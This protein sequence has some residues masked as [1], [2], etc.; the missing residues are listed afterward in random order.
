MANKYETTCC[1]I[2]ISAS[3]EKSLDAELEK[4]YKNKRHKESPTWHNHKN[5]TG[6]RASGRG[7][8]F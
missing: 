5:K 2:T 7:W 4:H 6:R 8:R 1:G 3:T